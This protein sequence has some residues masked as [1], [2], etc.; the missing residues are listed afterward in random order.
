MKPLVLIATLALIASSALADPRPI[1][2]VD[3]TIDNP[4][5]D[6][7][8]TAQCGPRPD[9]GQTCRSYWLNSGN[10]ASESQR[11]A[12]GREQGISKTYYSN[13]SLK[14]TTAYQNGKKHGIAQSYAADGTLQATT[15]YCQDTECAPAQK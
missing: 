3:T 9:G 4:P 7:A 15:H 1:S 2:C 8:S 13:G 10:L 11:D 6:K 12:Q 14:T 5:I